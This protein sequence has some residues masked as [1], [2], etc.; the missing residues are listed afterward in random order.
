MFPIVLYNFDSKKTDEKWTLLV[1]AASSFSL[2]DLN[3]PEEE[4]NELAKTVT[5]EAK[6]FGRRI[7]KAI[8]AAAGEIKPKSIILQ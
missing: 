8:L 6:I 2:N 5:R 4:A 7:E 3:L 1:T